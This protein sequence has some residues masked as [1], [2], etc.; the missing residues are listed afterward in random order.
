MCI[1]DSLLSLYVLRLASAS[2]PLSLSPSLRSPSLS[3]AFSPLSFSNRYG[4]AHST[5]PSHSSS[6]YTVCTRW[7]YSRLK[8]VHGVPWMVLPAETSTHAA[9]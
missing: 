5:Q 1:R 6:Q 7:Y 9:E 8:P 3:L 2:L 4:H